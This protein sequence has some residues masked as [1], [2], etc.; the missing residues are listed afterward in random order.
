MLAL[1]LKGWLCVCLVG[2]SFFNNWAGGHA[3][4]RIFLFFFSCVF[5]L[6]ILVIIIITLLTAF[7]LWNS[8]NS[9]RNY[10][11]MNSEVLLQANRLVSKTF[12][13]R[14]QWAKH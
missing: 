1:S 11:R 3:V 14:K 13:G 9:S 5:V 12:V 4:K 10:I 7:L 2:W 6:I 8:P